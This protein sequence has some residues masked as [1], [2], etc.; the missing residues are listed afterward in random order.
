MV[1]EQ[2]ARDPGDTAT[3]EELEAALKKAAKE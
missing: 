2:R 3:V 1:F